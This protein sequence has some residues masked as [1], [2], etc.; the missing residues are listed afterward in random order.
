MRDTF[1]AG[2]K[3]MGNP[4]VTIH[5]FVYLQCCQNIFR[6]NPECWAKKSRKSRA[7][8]AKIAEKSLVYSLNF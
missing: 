2:L 6:E 4:K 8:L 5:K 1:F 3:N 7:F